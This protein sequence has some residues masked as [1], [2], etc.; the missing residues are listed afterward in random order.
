MNK[1]TL[2]SG[3]I[4]NWKHDWK[5]DQILFWLE[6]VGTLGCVIAA[7]SLAIMAAHPKLLF[8]YC[9]YLVGSGCFL[10]ASYKRNNGWWVVLNSFFMSMDLL[11]IYNI[12]TN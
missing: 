6:L 11:G 3:I 10:T 5:N 1:K 9:L 2:L 7:G 8:T 12:I 4:E